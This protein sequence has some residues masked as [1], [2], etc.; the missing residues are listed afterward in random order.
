LV[1]TRKRLPFKLLHYEAHTNEKDARS[2]EKYFKTTKGKRTLKL[3]LKNSFS[4]AE[5]QF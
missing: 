2:Q 3:L 1:S 5:V 4:I